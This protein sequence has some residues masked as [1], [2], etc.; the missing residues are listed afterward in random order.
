MDKIFFT[1]HVKEIN[2]DQRTL[3]AYASTG[4]VDRDNEVIRPEAWINSVRQMGSVPLLWA[5]EYRVPPVGRAG[6]FAID[7]HGLKFTAKF[8]ATGFADEI[9]GLYR[10][11]F[12]DSFSVGFQPKVWEDHSEDNGPRRTYTE[13]ELHEI[14]AVPVPANPHARV[15]RDVI[16]VIGWK[17]LDSMAQLP[18]ADSVAKRGRVLNA[19]NEERIRQAAAL[20]QEVLST[21]PDEEP[22]E[23]S[24]ST[25]MVKTVIPYHD[26]GTAD[27][28]ESWEAPS[29]GDF[30]DETFADLTDAEK[31]RIAA[32]Y[33]W[34][35]DI[36]PEAF[37]DLKLPHHKA[38]KDGV[39]E[40]V[41]RGCA[42]AMSALMGG[43]GGVDMSEDDKKACHA[44]LSKH[45]EQFDREPPEMRAYS[46][47]EL[48]T[49]FPDVEEDQAIADAEPNTDD[50]SHDASEAADEDLPVDGRLAQSLTQF[51]QALKERF[52]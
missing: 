24:V 14:S 36:P 52:A 48:R 25:E 22:E 34:S 43:R 12:L 16:P 11:G 32:H 13:A 8:A 46:A 19:K 27:E 51:V 18:E 17:S 26:Q 1:G 39:G 38:Q 15:E 3:T 47:E 37:G 4:D 21:L 20:L 42:A 35:A 44:H 49:L 5:H 40:A 29:L 23:D 41:W 31:R 9:W 2:A 28:G 6:D 50:P 10:D 30:T 7:G 33:T 45:Y